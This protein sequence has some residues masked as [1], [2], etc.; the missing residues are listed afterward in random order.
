MA[1]AAQSPT[2]EAEGSESL[3]M[4]EEQRKKKEQIDKNLANAEKASTV[5]VTG[6]RN[7][8]VGIRKGF[9]LVGRG[10]AAVVDT[11]QKQIK[12]TEWHKEREAKKAET[13]PPRDP[14]K[15][16]GAF[17]GIVNVASSGVNAG[18]SVISGIKQGTRTVAKDVREST[19]TITEHS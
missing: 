1:I 13:T 10:G 14:N 3:E 12:K 8:K 9:G 2:V 4:T 5:F 17:T 11:S 15:G 16:E 18:C 19:I 6:T 7:V